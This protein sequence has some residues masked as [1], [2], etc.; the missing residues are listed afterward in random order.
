[1]TSGSLIQ[2]GT[3]IPSNNSFYAWYEYLSPS[4]PNPEV[5]T[6]LAIHPGDHIHVL[7]SYQ[8]SNGSASFYIADQTT[9]GS[10]AL[11]VNNLGSAYYDGRT[12][13]FIDERPLVGGTLAHLKNFGTNNWF[14]AQ[15]LTVQ[16][17]WGSLGSF[18]HV[19]AHMVTNGTTLAAPGFLK[20]G[21]SF[22]DN[23]VHCHG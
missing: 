20:T 3:A 19:R 5:R 10:R 23:W 1:V 2:A 11:T 15:A 13:D 17:S 21:S 6:S 12:A 14:N 16:G 8:R 18:N 7:V 9:G 22:Q 4:H